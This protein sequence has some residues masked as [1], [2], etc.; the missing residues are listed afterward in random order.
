MVRILAVDRAAVMYLSG[1]LR[2]VLNQKGALKQDLAARP[3]PRAF[4]LTAG[5]QQL[6]LF[7][8]DVRAEK[9]TDLARRLLRAKLESR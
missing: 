2:G 9:T 8:I 5:E 7:L 3:A 4:T 6:I 1:L